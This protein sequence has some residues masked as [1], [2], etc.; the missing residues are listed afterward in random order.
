[1]KALNAS[2]SP[3]LLTSRVKEY[4]AAIGA[5]D[6][7][8]RAAAVTI[9]DLDFE[10][11]LGYLPRTAKKTAVDVSA[12]LTRWDPVL[13]RARSHP[14]AGDVQTL[15]RVLSTPLMVGLARVVYSDNAVRDPL[16][17][18]EIGGSGNV[19]SLSAHL[20]D[21]FILAAYSQSSARPIGWHAGDAERWFLQQ[22]A[23]MQSRGLQEIG[24]W[25]IGD[26]IKRPTRMALAAMIAGGLAASLLSTIWQFG[27]GLG[28][29]FGA[30]IALFDCPPPR[31]APILFRGRRS[32]VRWLPASGLF[33]GAV[34]GIIGAL[35][36]GNHGL[37]GKLL[38]PGS[39]RFG[40]A[41]ALG[42]FVGSTTTVLTFALM[43]VTVLVGQQRRGVADW[44]RI[45]PTD[46]RRA[47]FEVFGYGLLWGFLGGLALGL[48][49]AL[50]GLTFGLGTSL[51][52]AVE[53]PVDVQAV[54]GPL[55]LLAIDRNN[56]LFLAA[57]F[58]P[59]FGLPVGLGAWF[60]LDPLSGVVMGLGGGL[61]IAMGIA[62]GLTA[63]GRWIIFTRCWLAVSG[64]AP[65]NLPK[66]LR[67][68]HARGVLRQAGAAYQFRHASLQARLAERAQGRSLTSPHDSPSPG[69]DRR[70]GRSGQSPRERWE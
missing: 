58:A 52:V 59:T 12:R 27:L 70:S 62:L 54:A 1:M 34:G 67:D 3:F 17:L 16:E 20:L 26:M 68:A 29:G 19:D 43:A 18:L 51:V 6:V 49:G 31:R 40:F 22:A 9:V 42:L 69:S 23:W 37:V 8:S 53:T 25:Q 13:Q 10:D 28:L 41:P 32:Q 4:K 36:G 60:A 64:R 35:V 33:G 56:A 5:T 65:R 7:L 45:R 11:V 66:F 15:R 55:D 48:P 38:A 57:L 14:D 47:V 21:A 63:W 39:G 2:R 30:A 46:A 44:Y 24:W 61:T 50:V